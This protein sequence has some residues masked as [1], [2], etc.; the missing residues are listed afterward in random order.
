VLLIG[1]PDKA[2]DEAEGDDDRGGG[3]NDGHGVD[4]FFRHILLY[5]FLFRT[6]IVY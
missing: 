2:K 4:C 1:P 5:H 6:L 3:E